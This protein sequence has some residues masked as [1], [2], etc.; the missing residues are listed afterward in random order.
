MDLILLGLEEDSSKF[1]SSKEKL[2]FIISRHIRIYTN[3]MHESK[4][5]LHEAHCLPRKY[6]EIIA[7]K[8]RKYFRTVGE[9]ISELFEHK[10]QKSQMTVLTFLLFGMCNWIYSWYDPKGEVTPAEL[11]NLICT[12][13]SEGIDK[14]QQISSG[15]PGKTR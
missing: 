12:I 2:N 11:S 1:K 13:V 4:T 5:L 8:E 6:F 9:V 15:K 14:L 10:I 7:E 3:S